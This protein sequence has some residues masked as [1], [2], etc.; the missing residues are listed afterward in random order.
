M[1]GLTWFILGFLS[2]GSVIF[3]REL[4]KRYRLNW[5]LFCSYGAGVVLVLF[6]I[7]WSVGA[8]LEGVPRA[9]S[10]GMLLFGLPGIVVLTLTLRNIFNRPERETATRDRLTTEPATVLEDSVQVQKVLRLPQF[11]P[12]VSTGLRYAAYLSLV[13]AFIAGIATGGNDYEAMVQAKFEGLELKKINDNP[14]VFQV[15]ATEGKPGEYILI[16]EGQGYGGPFVLGIRIKED[17]K[18]HEVIPL[19]D[20]ETPAFLKK[21]KEAN[22]REQFIGRGVTDNFI[23]GDDIDAVSGATVTTM[24]ATQAVRNGAH[25]AALQY[26]K[27]E[28]SW[29]SVPWKFGLDEILIIVLFGLAF[30]PTVSQKK[31]WKYVYMAGCVAIVGFYLNAAVSVGSL[32]GLLMGYIPNIHGGYWL[33]ARSWPS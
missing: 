28:P 23:V 16:T 17:A 9:G 14:V 1:M 30:V 11:S 31:P 12:R 25:I 29:K 18:V 33:S 7:A 6:S 10:M 26:F 24:A 13:V 3:Y 4:S 2:A 27:L 5:I 21:V 20:K 22:Y 15:N 8:V 32:S 19:S